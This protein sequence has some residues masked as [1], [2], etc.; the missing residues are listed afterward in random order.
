MRSEVFVFSIV[1]VSVSLPGVN[2]K[3][4]VDQIARA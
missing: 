2:W 3:S 1:T 4:P